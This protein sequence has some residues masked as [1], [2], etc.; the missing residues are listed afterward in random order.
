MTKR[1][2]QYS[3]T[4]TDKNHFIFPK[5]LGSKVYIEVSYNTITIDYRELKN[6]IQQNKYLSGI[7]KWQKG[8]TGLSDWV[9]VDVDHFETKN[10]LAINL[11]SSVSKQ[12]YGGNADLTYA[13]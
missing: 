9:K 7:E 3:D 1:F 5:T 13:F 10:R 2:C 8:V 12:I 11:C 4:D 6:T